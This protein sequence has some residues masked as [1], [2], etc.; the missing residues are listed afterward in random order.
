MTFTNFNCY[1][2][3]AWDSNAHIREDP[4]CTRLHICGDILRNR[5]I[6]RF[7]LLKERKVDHGWMKDGKKIFYFSKKGGWPRIW[8][9]SKN[10]E[11]TGNGRKEEK[12]AWP[13]KKIRVREGG[14][15][16]GLSLSTKSSS[17]KERHHTSV[18]EDPVIF[19]SAILLL[20]DL[21][22][23]G[24]GGVAQSIPHNFSS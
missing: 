23:F 14:R 11:S 8:K 17:F 22:F 21:L 9:G 24:G 5:E 10:R 6:R 13:K 19:Y 18:S 20:I 7:I 3:S 12:T 15:A 4:W 16:R 1:F 2:I